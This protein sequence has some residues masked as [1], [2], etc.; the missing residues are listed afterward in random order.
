MALIKSVRGKSPQWGDNC[1]LA[2]NAT[3][4]GDVVM[5]DECSVWF[6][7]VVRGDVNSIRI[8]NR[9]NIQDGAIIHCT[10]ER[11]R[12]IIED[13]V[14]IGHQAIVHGCTIHPQVLL[15]MGCR[16]MDHAVVE[17]GCIIAAGAVVLE[18]MVCEAGY[19]YAGVPARKV[20]PVSAELMEGEIRRI[21]NNYVKYASWY[22]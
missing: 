18:H 16:V 13:Y 19:I 15:G 4:T 11:S 22:K 2:D 3:L 10:Y 5:G 14:S 17:S 1:F 12:T 20:K 21:A 7:A 6:Q 8:G 9:V